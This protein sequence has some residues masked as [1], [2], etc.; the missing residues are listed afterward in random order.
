MGLTQNV[1][2]KNVCF[3][4][5]AHN[6][7]PWGSPDMI[8]IAFDG[9]FHEKKDEIPPSAH[10]PLKTLKQKQWV[11]V[12]PQKVEQK[13]WVKVGSQKVEKKQWVKEGIYSYIYI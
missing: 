6:S 4:K 5:Y 10:R 3:Y 9:K 13:Q 8:L 12:G 2:S 11:K 7:V 1:L